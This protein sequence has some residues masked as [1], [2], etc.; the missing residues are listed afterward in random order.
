[1]RKTEDFPLDPEIVAT[2]EAI[3][4]TLAGEAVDPRQAEVA[5]LAL[6]LSAERP[7]LDPAFST[8]LDEGFERRFAAAP[9]ARR[10][11]ARWWIW[12]PSAAMAASLA[13]AVVIVLGE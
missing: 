13:V 3:D 9:V 8:V 10:T 2:L 5:E 11:R 7:A 1:M 12:A 6:L 4:A